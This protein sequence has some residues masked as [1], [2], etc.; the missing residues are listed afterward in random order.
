MNGKRDHNWINFMSSLIS[1]FTVFL[2]FFLHLVSLMFL[3][4]LLLDIEVRRAYIV[5]TEY[6]SGV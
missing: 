1:L 2:Q 3:V 5:V 6:K 4:S